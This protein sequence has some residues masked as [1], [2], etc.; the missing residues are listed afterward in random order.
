M[1]MC[2]ATLVNGRYGEAEFCTGPMYILQ[3]HGDEIPLKIGDFAIKW[4]SLDRLDS[5]GWLTGVW[6]TK[7]AIL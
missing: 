6:T 4:S 1:I 2:R 5:A 3:F 7:R